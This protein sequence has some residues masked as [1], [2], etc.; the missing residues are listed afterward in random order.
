MLRS[1]SSLR[2][3]I[4][5]IVLALACALPGVAGAADHWGEPDPTFGTDG[6]IFPDYL[7]HSSDV[8]IQPDGK[9]LLAGGGWDGAVIKRFLPTGAVDTSFGV[10]GTFEF[11]EPAFDYTYF[12]SLVLQPDGK[13]VTVGGAYT[14]SPDPKVRGLILRLN[15]DGTLDTAA[16]STPATAFGTSDSGYVTFQD[17]TTETRLKSVA[18][19]STG[20]IIAGGSAGSGIAKQ[21]LVR[22]F[23]PE[24][25]DDATFNA[26]AID[27]LADWHS[28]N[29]E[30]V[31]ALASPGGKVSVLFRDRD[32][33]A[34]DVLRLDGDGTPDE[35]FHGDGVNV[36]EFDP[37]IAV[38]LAGAISTSDGGILAL[39]GLLDWSDYTAIGTAIRFAPSGEL[40]ESFGEGG[41]AIVTGAPWLDWN[42]AHTAAE[43]PQ[44]GFAVFGFSAG[45]DEGEANVSLLKD[46]G[47][48]NE[49]F[50][51]FGSAYLQPWSDAGSAGI[52]VQPNG[53][54]VATT[55][56]QYP[57]TLK[58][59]VER[60]RIASPDAPVTPKVPIKPRPINPGSSIQTPSGSKLPAGKL[61]FASGTAS[62]Y[63]SISRVAIALQKIDGKELK[64]G[65]CLYLK[66]RDAKFKR[67]SATDGRCDSP[68]WLSATGT[69]NWYYKLKKQLPK[70]RYL[71]SVRATA[72]DGTRQAL[73]TTK[74]FRVK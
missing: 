17:G 48:Y 51:D 66:N 39:G 41:V 43:L 62:P 33:E 11:S 58:T 36:L 69:S 61:K 65:K 21:E 22:R 30:N 8:A 6:V 31:F 15:S 74:K 72:T 26:N 64:R 29:S 16:D 5:S 27:S 38:S 28:E 60:L 46:D 3:G 52:A 73:A 35:D 68:F 42:I 23:T 50:G 24:G 25:A 45:D 71:L 49:A 37:D 44:G 1:F 63:G 14:P 59:F 34:I 10:G 2:I 20:S 19:E 47:S 40:D 55:T 32:A 56:G 54:I 12:N 13:I 70:G 57:T 4:V 53:R 9:I 18:L 7:D 67:V